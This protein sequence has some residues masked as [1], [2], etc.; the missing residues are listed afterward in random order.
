MHASGPLLTAVE[1]RWHLDEVVK[2]SKALLWE[3]VGDDGSTGESLK[4]LF[5][6]AID[7]SGGRCPA[8][9]SVD[10]ADL[11]LAESSDFEGGAGKSKGE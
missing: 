8:G 9:V 2:R 6:L 5:G 3:W 4:L 11:R 7:E 1:L 10:V